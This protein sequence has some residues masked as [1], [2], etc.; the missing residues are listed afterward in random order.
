MDWDYYY[1]PDENEQ[2]KTTTEQDTPQDK[3][4]L[5]ITPPLQKSQDKEQHRRATTSHRKAIPKEQKLGADFIIIESHDH[6]EACCRGFRS[7]F[8]HPFTSPDE[9]MTVWLRIQHDNTQEGEIYRK[10]VANRAA[11][12]ATRHSAISSTPTVLGA[13]KRTPQG[14]LGSDRWHG[15]MPIESLVVWI[16][17][18][19]DDREETAVQEELIQEGKKE[20]EKKRERKWSFPVCT[21]ETRDQSEE[22][23]PSSWRL[24]PRDKSEEKRPSFCGWMRQSYH[25]QY[26]WI[27]GMSVL[28][29]YE[30]IGFYPLDRQFLSAGET[31]ILP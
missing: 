7:K 25:F 9:C 21:N 11:D 17:A 12:H 15:T 27:Y 29:W 14:L 30:C 18:L 23:R 3:E 13:L 19:H 28:K 6:D 24:H 16:I 20:R 31:H 8:R 2:I 26:R 5:K 10:T 1:K 22:Q 4:R